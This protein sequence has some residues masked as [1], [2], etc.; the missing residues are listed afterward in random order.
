MNIE[1]PIKSLESII[2]FIKESTMVGDRST[3]H[4]I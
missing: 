3:S 4:S 1:S 2:E